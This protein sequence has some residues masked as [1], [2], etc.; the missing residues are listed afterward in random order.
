MPIHR[1]IF[2]GSVRNSNTT[3]GGASILISRSTSS[4]LVLASLIPAPVVG[5]DFALEDLEV[6]GPEVVQERAQL[7]Q[8]L[9]PGSVDA[10]GAVSA[11]THEAGIAQVPQV[12]GDGL[13]G[14]IEARGDLTRGQLPVADE[15]Q[16]LASPWL[17]DGID[18]CLQ[19]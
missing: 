4:A 13:A 6:L 10:S 14:D 16:D 7:G 15:T 18:G 12:L 3:E 1:T 19:R 9:G 5:F 17:G 11:L 2:A 8:T